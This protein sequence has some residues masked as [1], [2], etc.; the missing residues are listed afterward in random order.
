MYYSKINPAKRVAGLFIALAI[1]IAPLVSGGALFAETRRADDVFKKWL[2]WQKTY[3]DVVPGDTDYLD[4]A[5]V[6]E[7]GKTVPAAI[8][9]QL[10]FLRLPPTGASTPQQ[11][12]EFQTRLRENLSA[13]DSPRG[14][15]RWIDRLKQPETG[16]TS[17]QRNQTEEADKFQ[18]ITTKYREFLEW[19]T[20]PGEFD[21]ITGRRFAIANRFFEYCFGSGTFSHFRELIGNPAWRPIARMLYA[22]VWYN[23]SGNG[24]RYWHA[25]TLKALRERSLAGD[26][27]VYIAGGSDIYLP[28]ANDIY[29]IRII[30]PMFPSQVKY[31]SEGWEYLIRGAGP[32]GGIGDTITFGGNPYVI[33]RRLSYKESGRFETGELSDGKKLTLPK[34]ETVWELR[35]GGG[36]YLG[37]F[38]LERRFVTQADFKVRSNQAL[39]ISFNEL[40]YITAAGSGGWGIDA[41][42]F[43]N[44]VQMYVKQLRQ[45][46]DK[47]VMTNM[48]EMSEADFYYIKL[49]TSVD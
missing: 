43:P 28:I 39:L 19:I 5:A 47:T 44:G 3:L 9:P 42:E 2:S 30:D 10:G 7:L 40:Y 36:E 32:D 8:R 22:N 16:F 1:Y 23:L 38:V 24:W 29:N 20:T 13:F 31:Y 14:L 17:L 15:A 35:D 6:T 25:S 21:I 27:I 49:G 34:S 37:R 4:A 48:R 46:I 33:M 11:R 45:P 41:R 12:Q 18:N 26:E